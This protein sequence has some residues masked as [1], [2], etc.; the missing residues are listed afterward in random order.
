LIKIPSGSNINVREEATTSS[1][2][3]AKIKTSEPASKVAEEGDWTKVTIRNFPAGWVNNQFIGTQDEASNF[4]LSATD[5]LKGQKVVISETPT[6]WLRV[7]NAPWGEEIGKVYPG[8][9]Y[10]ILDEID[11]WFLVEI[12][13]GQKGWI[14]SEFAQVQ[15][16][17]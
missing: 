3:L 7:R 11:D 17:D 10:V 14:S 4:V 5:E 13:E 9:S 15:S 1:K 6:D 12:S 16:V 8:E 2:I